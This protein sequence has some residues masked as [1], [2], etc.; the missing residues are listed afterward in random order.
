[1]S[2]W[3]FNIYGPTAITEKKKLWALLGE[4]VRVLQGELFILGGDFNAILN[5]SEKICGILPIAKVMMDLNQFIVDSSF[6]DVSP[7]A[8][9]FT[10]ANRWEDFCS[11][12]KHLDRFLLVDHYLNT[13][14]DYHSVILPLSSSDYYPILL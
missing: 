5:N 13:E 7:K 2:F 4:I 11:I 12:S 8:G 9:K 3:L 14:M 10:W 6:L 1:M